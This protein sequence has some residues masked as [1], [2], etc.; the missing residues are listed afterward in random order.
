MSHLLVGIPRRRRAALE[1][2]QHGPIMRA[3]PAHVIAHAIASQW[4]FMLD[5]MMECSHDTHDR[6][7][8]SG[9]DRLPGR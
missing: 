6:S 3:A 1:P 4:R 5:A 9:G 2:E 7:T 8:T